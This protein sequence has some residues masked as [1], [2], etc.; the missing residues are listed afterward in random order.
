M[1]T[2]FPTGSVFPDSESSNIVRELTSDVRVARACEWF[3]AHAA[4]ITESHVKICEI[5]A[6]PFNETARANYLCD[7]FRSLGLTHCGLDA[8]GNAV[9]LRLGNSLRPLLVVSA[10]LDTVFPENTD[11]TVKRDAHILR[12]PGIA[13]DGCG[14]AAL[15]AL[16]EA[17]NDSEIKTEGSILFVGTVGEEGAGDLRGARHLLTVGEWKTSVDAFISLDGPGLERIT[18]GALGSRRYRVRFGGQGGHSWGDFGVAHPVHAMANA[19]AKL[20]LYQPPVNPRTTF[21][22]GRI[23]GGEGVNVIPSEA[24]MEVDLRSESATELRR[25]DDYFLQT[26]EQTVRA[27]NQRRRL[28]TAALEVNLKLIGNRPSG[29]TPPESLIVRL[30]EAATRALNHTPHLDCSSTDSNIA[31]SL[32][33]PAVTIGAGGAAAYSHTLEEWYDPTNRALGLK[34]NLLVMLGLVKIKE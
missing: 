14:L 34:R 18:N 8:E 3:T 17:L 11:F 16:I 30:A 29:V 32:G 15:G 27:E 31:I 20:N 21:N 28:R 1:A 6:S 22:V 4:R 12:A 5:P 13:D 7:I 10:H 33:I 26:I 9:G 2:V 24:T 19:I 25:L 23:E